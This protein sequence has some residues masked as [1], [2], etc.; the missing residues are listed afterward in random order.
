MIEALNAPGGT[1]FG[2]CLA[3]MLGLFLLELA[4]T[5][6]GGNPIDHLIPDFSADLNHDGIPDGIELHGFAGSIMGWLHVGRV[7][8]MILLATFLSGWGASGLL[9]QSLSMGVLGFYLPSL[10]AAPI[11]FAAGLLAT[12]VVGKVLS[13]IIPS[14]ETAAVSPN[15]FVGQ[16]AIITQGTARQGFSAEARLV[17]A[18][19][20]THYLRVEPMNETPLEPGTEVLL[21]ERKEA[22][23][24]VVPATEI[25]S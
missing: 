11:G 22:V 16:L 21:L 8:V 14:D 7:P 24:L 20:R 25:S 17:D 18:H 4:A 3:L 15:Q 13:R 12:H 19:G 10:I 9:L 5:F 6:F 2:V 1:L 23:F